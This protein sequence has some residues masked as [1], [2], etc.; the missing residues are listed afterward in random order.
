MDYEDAAT[1]NA[2]LA[3]A[4]RLKH[5]LPGNLQHRLDKIA[6]QFPDSIYK[7]HDFAKQY[8]PLKYEYIAVLQ[9]L[10]RE[11]TRLK[12]AESQPT[13][14]PSQ[15]PTVSWEEVEQQLGTYFKDMALDLIERSHPD[16]DRKIAEALESALVDM[17]SSPGMTSEE[18][19]DWLTQ[20]FE[21]SDEEL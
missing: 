15:E 11:G 2:F 8:E 19:N 10:P 7:L 9:E 1:L 20:V 17:K 5:P 21:S 13:E 6:E 14:P 4:T 16:Y 3:A 18:F 12:F